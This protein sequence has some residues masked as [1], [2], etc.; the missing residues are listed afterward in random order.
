LS[1]SARLICT[2]AIVAAIRAAAIALLGL[3]L[4][5]SPAAAHSGGLNAEGC[6]NNRKT[7]E[8][9]CHRGGSAPAGLGQKRQ[10]FTNLGA[11]RNCTEARAAGAAPVRRGDPGYGRHLDRDDDGVGCEPYRGR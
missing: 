7:G 1:K 5:G 4:S 11:F 2:D 9:H 6:H 10:S 8:Y 3:L